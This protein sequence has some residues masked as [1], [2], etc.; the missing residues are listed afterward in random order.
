MYAYLGG[1]SKQID[2][3]P[4]QIGGFEDHV[5]ILATLG[6]SQTQSDWVKE[7][8]R[9]SN[10]WLKAQGNFFNDFEWQRGYACFSVSQSNLDSVQKYIATQVEHHKDQ[11]FQAELRKLLTKHQLAWDEKYL[12]D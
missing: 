7:L 9:V 5:H 8:K 3:P 1:I 11:S 2:C 4:I 10:L 6:R 12:W